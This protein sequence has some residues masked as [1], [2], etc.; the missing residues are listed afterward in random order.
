MRVFTIIILSFA[1][2]SLV[3]QERTISGVL[4]SSDDGG[5]LPGI[6]IVVKGT[7]V[8]TVTDA[9]GYYSIKV[10]V[11]STLVFSFVGMQTREVVVTEDN[12]KPVKTTTRQDGPEQKRK[13]NSLR[14]IPR[15]LYKDSVYQDGTGIAVLTQK[16]PTYSTP[17][18]SDPATTRQITKRG[19][20]YHLKTDSDPS[21]WRRYTVQ[22]STSLA[23]E[24]INKLPSLQNEFAQ[25]RTDGSKLQWRG[26]DQSEIFSWGPLRRTLE[27]DGSNYP[28]D[29]NGKLV[30]SGSG[31]GKAANN[32]NALPF[33]RSGFTNTNEILVAIRSR[34]FATF[35]FD[36]EQRTR[37]GIIPN[38]RYGKL[39]VGASVRNLRIVEGVSA[40][41]SL[42]YNTSGGNLVNRGAN[43]ATIVGAVYHAPNTFDIANGLSSK[44]ARSAAASYQFE[45]G[46]KRSHAPGIAD[47]PYGLVNDLPDNEEFHRIIATTNLRYATESPFDLV[48]NGSLDKQSN[49]TTFGVPPGYAGSPDGRLTNRMDDQTFANSILTASYSY[50]HFDGNLKLS[51]S[52][53]ADYTRR[54]L[55]RE[56]GYSFF[57]GSYGDMNDAASSRTLHKYLTRTAQEIVFNAQYELYNWI[58]VRLANRIC[59][60]NT[61]N[62]KQFT[63]LFPS[64][65]LSVN[66]AEPL[67]MS[68]DEMK[69]YATMSRTIREAPLLY[70]SWSYGSTTLPVGEYAAFYE[71]NELT[72]TNDIVP[73]IERKFETGVKLQSGGFNV[74]VSYFNNRTENFVAPVSTSEGFDL[75]NVARI[76]NYGGAISAGYFGYIYNGHWGTDLKWTKYNSVV[77]EIYTPDDWIATAGFQ[78]AHTALAVGLPTGSIYG[79]SYVRND[80]GAKVIGADGFP[81]KDNNLKMIGNPIPDWNLGW[82]S[83]IQ[84]NQFRFSWLL[85]IKKGGDVW[86]GTNAVLD[87][88]GRSS[89]TGKHRNTSNYVFEGVDINGVNNVTPVSLY[90][91]AK[92]ISDNRWVRYGW[93]GIGEDYIEDA[94]WVRL[95]ELVLSY[96][97]SRPRNAAIKSIKIS[98]IGRNLFLITPYTGVD[99]SSNLFGYTTGSGLDLFNTP[100]VRSY[101]AQ[102]T[103]QI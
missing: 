93:D 56:D 78:N 13:A 94:S 26:A 30:S 9:N 65:S 50:E 39:N 40:S 62:D 6:N 98:L 92:P 33:F 53:Q 83:Y 10:P 32:Y 49:T 22:F 61:L 70:S 85:D 89:N 96:T 25:G 67:S 5:P 18:S 57:E 103:I 1:C 95:S 60:S 90:E 14:P 84:L 77:E 64:G 8:G 97:L 69:L 38:S 3:A 87:Y 48:F 73:E 71:A 43:L 74:D 99:P 80:E 52:H 46:S 76:K 44:E 37:S 72:F 11:G 55:N 12:L 27:F 35:T 68:V 17:P 31:N 41:A 19:N 34:R 88:L 20:I 63:N 16:S 91:T 101:S 29:K 58:N 47:N 4:T 2:H 54:E 81:L 66:L 7:D 45:D 100:S 75:Q 51:L 59:F 79:S 24:Q 36:L 21:H 28:F 102:F 15:S 86:N 42:Y 23:I 82:S